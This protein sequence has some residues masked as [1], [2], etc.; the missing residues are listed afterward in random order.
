VSAKL[1]CVVTV[2]SLTVEDDFSEAAL[3]VTH[4]GD[5]GNPMQV[6]ANRTEAV[7]KGVVRLADLEA[8]L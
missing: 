5:R 2:S 7:P 3:V 1:R 6:L 8:C 4:L